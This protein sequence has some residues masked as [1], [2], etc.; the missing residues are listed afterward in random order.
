MQGYLLQVWERTRS[1]VLM[2]TH[3]FDEALALADRIV[4]IGAQPAGHVSRVID[5]PTPRLSN[6]NDPQI[7]RI[8]EELNGFLERE[9][10]E[11]EHFNS[12]E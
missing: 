2:V 6:R 8:A 11:S 5:I 1:T 9:A 12:I 10:R 7:R 3:D 4:L